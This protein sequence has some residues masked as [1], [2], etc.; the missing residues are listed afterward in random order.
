VETAVVRHFSMTNYLANQVEQIEGQHA[1][2]ARPQTAGTAS[3]P[4]YGDGSPTAVALSI[5]ATPAPTSGCCLSRST[6]NA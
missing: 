2:N 6:R 3:F 4:S 1:I 5:D